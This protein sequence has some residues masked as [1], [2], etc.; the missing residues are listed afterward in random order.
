MSNLTGRLS[1]ARFCREYLTRSI[2]DSLYISTHEAR[3]C[4]PGG[5]EYVCVCV[6]VCVCIYARAIT[7]YT[8]INLNCMRS[9]APIMRPA[10]L[11][12][13][14]AR[15]QVRRAQRANQPAFTAP[16]R[17]RGAQRVRRAH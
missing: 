14:R 17:M 2:T 12:V 7:M 9:Y 1:H 5:L 6:C 3:T 16:A 10:A 13:I 11:T 4:A 15:E 8:H